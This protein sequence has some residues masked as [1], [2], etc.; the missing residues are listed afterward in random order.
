VATYRLSS[1]AVADLR[2]IFRY[3]V[4]EFGLVQADA[5]ADA[6][7]ATFVFLA[8]YPRVARLRTEV[9]PPVRA[10]PFRRHLI[11]YDIF[12]EMIVIQRVRHGREDWM[13]GDDR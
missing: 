10:Y 1:A 9:V 3:G 12:G 13:R 6:L 11:V 5:Y 8:E 7:T 2:A 4:E